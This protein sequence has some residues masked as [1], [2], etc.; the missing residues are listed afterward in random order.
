[1][2]LAVWSATPP[3]PADSNN[4]IVVA[5]V[6]EQNRNSDNSIIFKIDF[7]VEIG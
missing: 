3:G 4:V 2:C 5:I 6:D 7:I 1:M